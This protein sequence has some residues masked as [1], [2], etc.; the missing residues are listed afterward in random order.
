MFLVMVKKKKKKNL[1]LLTCATYHI[2][3]VQRTLEKKR[4]PNTLHVTELHLLN[5]NERPKDTRILC[6]KINRRVFFCEKKKSV[7]SEAE[8]KFKDS[9]YLKA[10]SEKTLRRMKQILYREELTD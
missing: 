5:R 4:R 2:R 9:P 8:I 3:K 7:F 10:E 6:L 1:V